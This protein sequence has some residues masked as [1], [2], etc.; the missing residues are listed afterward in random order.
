MGNRAKPA[1]LRIVEGNRGHRPIPQ[2]PAIPPSK[3]KMPRS[4]KGRKAT[5]WKY[6]I[7]YTSVAPGWITADNAGLLAAYVIAEIT[8]DRLNEYIENKGGE[9][10][11]IEWCQKNNYRH[12]HLLERN[13]ASKEVN[14]LGAA[15][16]I[17]PTARGRIERAGKK[18]E[19]NEDLD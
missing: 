13:K 17:Q 5:A 6:Y 12:I 11:Y 3:P 10:K 7:E 14:T 1:V 9:A 18:E 15:L 8:L 19:G 4:F 16:G 2:E